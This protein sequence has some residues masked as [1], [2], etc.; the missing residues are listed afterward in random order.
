MTVDDND[1]ILEII[2]LTEPEVRWTRI[3]DISQAPMLGEKHPICLT[4]KLLAS[5]SMA[6]QCVQNT[7]HLLLP[8]KLIK[9]NPTKRNFLQVTIISW[10]LSAFYK[11][12]QS[13]YTKENSV[14]VADGQYRRQPTDLS[15]IASNGNINAQETDQTCHVNAAKLITLSFS[16]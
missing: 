5:E 8:I 4:R 14:N 6:S 2:I 7:S 12:P 15:H 3:G 11:V 16:K 13:T 9:Y 10:L 1:I